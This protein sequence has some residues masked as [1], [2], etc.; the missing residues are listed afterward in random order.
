MI[1]FSQEREDHIKLESNTTL[2]RFV[3]TTET[4]CFEVPK[5][6]QGGKKRSV[7]VFFNE[8]KDFDEDEYR[9]AKMQL[10]DEQG[11]ILFEWIK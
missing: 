4:E 7:G 3:Y 2:I 9:V 5:N 6:L 10:H 1:F 8:P 11:N